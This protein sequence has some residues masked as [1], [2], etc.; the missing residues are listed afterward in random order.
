MK[1][2]R[3]KKHH[4]RRRRMSGATLTPAAKTGF[5]ILAGAVAGAIAKRFLD[6]AIAKQDTVKIEPKT[7][8]FLE[9]VAGGLIVY[10]GKMPFIQGIGIGVAAESTVKIAQ[11]M[12]L[13]SG[14]AI[15]YSNFRK[16]GA[17]KPN[18]GGNAITPSVA[19]ANIYNFPKPSQVGRIK[20]FAAAS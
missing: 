15:N 7:L 8:A 16:L 18:M 9:L 12:N 11:E 10:T 19:G 1:R 4:H 20:K 14:P 17:P 13:I 5:E 2:G 3:K 6:S